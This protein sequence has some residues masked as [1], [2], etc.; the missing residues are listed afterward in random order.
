MF[1]SGAPTC[2]ALTGFT[3]GQLSC[4]FD[5]TTGVLLLQFPASSADIVGG[6]PVSFT[7][8]GFQNPYNGVPKSGFVATSL[9]TVTGGKVDET[10]PMSVTCTEFADLSSPTLSRDA[11]DPFSSNQVS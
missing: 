9:D 4:S 2:T 5:T 3:A 6:T 7:I 11:A 10:V 8:S 1:K